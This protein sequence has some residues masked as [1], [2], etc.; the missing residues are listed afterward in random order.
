[1]DRITIQQL[2]RRAAEIKV[3]TIPPYEHV[4]PYFENKQLN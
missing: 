4:R 2:V 1:M 3:V